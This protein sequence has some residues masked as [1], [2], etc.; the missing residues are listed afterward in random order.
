MSELPLEGIIILDFATLLAGPV[1]TTIL[2][3]FG[4]T[5]IKIELPK[6]GDSTRGMGIFPSGRGPSWLVEGRNKKAITLD[7]HTKEGQELAH[8]LAAKADAVVMNFRPGRAEGWHIGS[9]DLHR[10]NP[11]LI[12]AQV[13]AYGQTGP[14]HKKGGFDRTA[15]AFGG[16][17]YVTGFPDQPPVRSGYALV[18]YMTAYLG[19]FGLVMALYNRKVNG[20]GGEVI[21]ISLVESGFRA[22]E[23]A[24]VD[25]SLS[26]RIRERTGNRNPFVV[27]ADDFETKDGRILVINAGVDTLW[28]KLAYAIGHPELLEDPRFNSRFARIGNQ[29]QLYEIVADW[30][31]DLTA[32]EALEIL[33]QAEVPADIIRNIEDLAHDPHLR[34]RDAV[35]E[36]EDPEQG[37]VLVPGVFPK[38]TK[39]PGRIKFLGAKLG[40]HNQE[41]YSEFLGLSADEITELEKKGVI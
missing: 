27:P 24:L 10:T 12:I 7:L 30:V 3:D 29:D 5:I 21:D 1:S 13:S 22:S 2:G 36:V 32:D 14:Y 41:I 35:L 15:S 18:D 11:E 40:E 17:T 8:K 6:V 38:L 20:T 34:A 16:I 37:K 26:G 28:T 9:E 33:D 25:Y 4:A 31:K 23:S 19:A 39:H